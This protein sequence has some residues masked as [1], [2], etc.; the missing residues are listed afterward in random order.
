MVAV[1][2]VLM[3]LFVL[4]APFLVTVRNA[5]QA[6]SEAADRS[7]LRL[8]LDSAARHAAAELSASHPAL[9]RTPYFD[10]LEELTVTSRFPEGFLATSDPTQTMWG[11]AAEDVAARVDLASASPHVLANLIG[12]TARLADA[13]KDKDTALALSG[14]EGLLAE[15]VV[16]LDDEWI[17]YAELTGTKLGKLARGLLVKLD[18]K[19]EPLE[20]GP[21]P[22]RSHEVGA[23][24]LDQ[25][26]FALCEWRMRTSAARGELG[27]YE[28]IEEVREAGDLLL[29]PELGREAYLALERTTSTF[30][31]VRAGARWQR[32]VRLLGDPQGEPQYGCR[33]P[34]DDLRWFNP[35]TTVWITDGTKGEYALV[36]TTQAGALVLMGPL[37][38]AFTAGRTVVAP[39]ARTPVNVNTASAEVLK[40]LWT[41][42]K[43][44]GKSARITEGEAEQ[45]V[46][47]ALVSRPFTGFEDL[48]R[49]LVLPAAGLDEL[50]VDA[51]V[52]PE[53]LEQ[54]AR[55]KTLDANGDEV[56]AGFIDPDD[57]RAF[58]KN[59]LNANDAELEF[60]TMP[61]CFTAR[62]VY[63]IALR[64]SI[65]APSGVQRA[66]GLRELAELIVPQ[67]D[68]LTV[69]T[70]QEDFDEAPR[71]DRAASGWLSGPV[72]TA[73]HDALFGE[74]SSLRWPTRARAHLGPH[75]SAPAVDPLADPTRV[76][77]FPVR[78][79][80]DGWAQLAPHRE[81]DHARRASWALHF[82]DETKELE[83]R[84]LPDG[85]APLDLA[86]LGWSGGGQLMGGMAFSL[87]VQPRELEEGA[88]L[89]D[90]GGQYSDSDRLSLLFE[91]GDLVLRVLDGAGDHPT[92]TFKE[93]SEVRF[94][95][96][97]AGPGLPEGAWSH[98]QIAVEGTRPDQ[99][100]LWVDGRRSEDT[101]GLTR[102][103][104]D[105]TSESDTLIVES[106]AGFPDKCVVRIGQEL[107]EVL[108]KSEKTFL[109]KFQSLGENAGFGGRIA[110][111]HHS[112]YPEQNLGLT[113]AIDH[114]AGSSVQ[115]YGY[116]LPISSNVPNVAGALD[117]DQALFYV[118]RVEGILKGGS[119]KRLSAMEPITRQGTLFTYDLGHGL[120]G[121]GDDVEG[122]LLQP[123]DP[124]V[125]IEEVMET[126]S[127]RGGYAAILAVT[128]G[129][130]EA[131]WKDLN[132]TRIGGVEV[133]RYSGWEGHTL[134]IA[135]RGDAVRLK[136]LQGEG[137]S[138]DVVG[139]A[140]F[141]IS[142]GTGDVIDP[143]YLAHD[144]ELSTQVMVMPISVPV[145]IAAGV[146][147]FDPAGTSSAFA[148]IT[149]TGN[150]AH[151]TEWVRYDEISPEGF[152]V[153]DDSQAL[154]N[155]NR[156][157]HPGWDSGVN[158][159]APLTP[160]SNP[161]PIVLASAP[162][163]S[164]W[165]RAEPRVRPPASQGG[166][167]YWFY[168]MGEAEDQDF[169]VSRAVNSRFQF[170]GVLGTYV[171]EHTTG[172]LVLPVF[173][174][175]DYDETSGWPGR[176]DHVMFQTG[177]AAEPGFPGV[178]HH[179]HRPLDYLGYS[180][181][182]GG[183]ALSAQAIEEPA[184]LGQSGF[185][186]SDTHLALD[187]RL[188]VPFVPSRLVDEDA[189]PIDTRLL[190]RMALFPS[191]ELPRAVSVGQ[192][193]GD[194]RQPG[195]GVPSVEID[196]A[197]FFPSFSVLLAGMP[198]QVVVAQGIDADDEVLSVLKETLRTPLGDY[199]L[200]K[201]EGGG[202]TKAKKEKASYL[203]T[204][205]FANLP[206]RG[207][208]LRVGD[209]LLCYE[210]FEASTNVVRFTL[211]HGGRG[212][213]GT[214]PQPHRP[215]EGVSFA[216]SLPVGILAS[217]LRPDDALIPLLEVPPGFPAHGTV[218]IDDELVHYVRMQGAVLEMP[219]ASVEPGERDEKGPGLF[220]GRYGTQRADHAAG[221][222]V[223]LFPFRY[224]DR[225][226]E[227]ADAPEMT[228]YQL[229]CDQPD[230]YWKRV[231]W[232]VSEPAFP[233]AALGVLQ[234]TN[235]ETPW[236]AP[237]EGDNGLALFWEGKL[238]GEG[239]PIGVQS[240]RVEWRIFV[241]HL[242][243][244][245][246]PLEGLAHGWK[247]TPRLELFGVE[248]MGPSRT[249]ARVDR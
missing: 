149:R 196:E 221:T 138:P 117:S 124:S 114:P 167:S 8:T 3:A 172:T 56:L 80:E 137:V 120:D 29:G 240:D 174:A 136:N 65:N 139:R 229:A 173:R 11:L 186:T 85:P 83:G 82:D 77:C 164:V 125:A 48:L 112:G 34:V 211:A 153:R 241:R 15:G 118:A 140:A 227:L 175:R 16:L 178:V 46:D 187:D 190:S 69:W 249:L 170:R 169:V 26:A 45:L 161:S 151:L 144:Q 143:A 234:R 224:W 235:A 49:R 158:P 106:T 216:G 160:P 226:S 155:A 41:N 166:Q 79:D 35:G 61:L 32:A 17:G 142:Y 51:P 95:L 201:K 145:Q 96:R 92:S 203:K 236:D 141:V 181:R 183:G 104:R 198:G 165:K 128:Y 81:D 24:V 22:P 97:G 116:S 219:R 243:G 39:L 67:R 4:S 50:P 197:L 88:R 135:A 13:C 208:L 91:S 147:G 119:E 64:A 246:D 38:A 87:W 54:L 36:R 134:K 59:A 195:A 30:G 113:K 108:R 159:P 199:I 189:N 215:T 156:A 71:L 205:P 100:G 210:S 244:S 177:D 52:R 9:D 207:G 63:A 58:Y 68:L 93:Q 31:R 99:M 193:G 105:L 220:R 102:L 89:L 98:L 194:V 72:P 248:Y 90:V 152:L 239:N 238:D 14:T 171:H 28:S 18:E 57:A 47:L 131:R 127:P 185:R 122:L 225:W 123:T 7:V 222:P 146:T 232:K 168:A 74:V 94:A 60:S 43:L 247:T 192:L 44:R 37:R 202:E 188:A 1:L 176:F 75:D 20:C 121:L 126:F 101:P 191:G 110:R 70:R 133:I 62:D 182:D 230:A 184:S 200:D 213:F 150:D 245:F 148:Q 5:D 218:R 115:L 40:A 223:I 19:G 154:I 130:D 2:L 12:G 55:Q 157:A 231:F 180:W 76:Y 179:A 204:D 233:G 53:I 27:A 25:R 209:E 23:F 237:P 212:L 111:E 73:R 242:A 163:R 228:W 129:P 33:L 214:E 42:L 78:E 86:K 109:A 21:S 66:R 162:P 132:G 10:D 103:T 84:F 217:R 107:I 206:E 6:S